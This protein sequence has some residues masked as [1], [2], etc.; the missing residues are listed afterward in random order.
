MCSRPAAFVY[1]GLIFGLLS[2]CRYRQNN[3]SSWD[4]TCYRQNAPEKS[5]SSDG[6]STPANHVATPNV[7]P[8][9][10]S[11]R[12]T[13]APTSSASRPSVEDVFAPRTTWSSRPGPDSSAKSP[14][15]PKA[16]TAG[17]GVSPSQPRP[18]PRRVAFVVPLH[19]PRAHWGL[20]LAR[21]FY[22]HLKTQ[23]VAADL[24]FIYS[25]P[26][27][28]EATLAKE[29]EENG[30][31]GE[32]TAT[33][34][35]F[36]SDT[37]VVSELPTLEEFQS[38]LKY[39]ISFQQGVRTHAG[40]KRVAG[41]PGDVKQLFA[42]RHLCG[43]D[44]DRRKHGTEQTLPKYEYVA[45]FDAEVMF[46][47]S[48]WELD[49]AEGLVGL[50]NN[51]YAKK[52]IYAGT[53]RSCFPWV[54]QA[55]YWMGNGSYIGRGVEWT[56]EN[57]G[58]TWYNQLP[59]LKCSDAGEFLSDIGFPPEGGG[60]GR[61]GLRWEFMQ[62]M[63]QSWLWGRRNWSHKRVSDKV[64]GDVCPR[65]FCC[66]EMLGRACG[67]EFPNAM[68]REMGNFWAPAEFLHVRAFRTM[69]ARA[70]F[71]GGVEASD[72][73]LNLT[74][75]WR[76][77]R[78]RGAP[79]GG[80]P[81]SSWGGSNKEVVAKK[82]PERLSPTGSG[83][84]ASSPLPPLRLPPVTSISSKLQKHYLGSG[85]LEKAMEKLGETKVFAAFHGDRKWWAAEVW[86]LPSN[87]SA[88]VHWKTGEI[89]KT[90]AVFGREAP[91]GADGK[92]LIE[93][94]WQTEPGAGWGGEEE[95]AFRGGL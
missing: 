10:S 90:P 33:N 1:I 52:E 68:F 30:G 36:L 3:K 16:T 14:S 20:R 29:T 34:P 76:E 41:F 75:E 95:G 43:S 64:A 35:L 5:S 23:N 18:P 88:P 50:F 57:I 21:S 45:F 89:G 73:L 83:A 42:V 62:L 77:R 63:V 70:G 59:F 65:L 38:K 4:R 12:T 25:D 54:G 9:Q 22:F 60:L 56:D 6:L 71:L 17:P 15:P 67:D 24:F 47:R 7:G 28:R 13:T 86:Y 55:G 51:F 11:L 79:G 80:S 69:H 26:A 78:D 85:L 2:V 91:R 32:E 72:W 37:R 53:I 82:S 27:D 19:P 84:S 46:F 31:N 61:G 39:R 40:Q 44:A 74:L 8:S 49:P 48:P 92:L 66:L 94:G 93:A 87:E 58:Y 81:G